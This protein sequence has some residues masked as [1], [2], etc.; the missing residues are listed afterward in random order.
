MVTIS[1]E[2]PHTLYALRR[3]GR[4]HSKP[5][6]LN[7]D[8][9][10]IVQRMCLPVGSGMAATFGVEHVFTQYPAVQLIRAREATTKN[11]IE[12]DFESCG[13][14]ADMEWARRA[15]QT[16]LMNDGDESYLGPT[17]CVLTLTN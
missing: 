3:Q 14:W 6:P 13:F 10:A 1:R 2:F 16:R 9:H 7:A 17:S 15:R 11:I 8:E 4:L 12:C 5:H